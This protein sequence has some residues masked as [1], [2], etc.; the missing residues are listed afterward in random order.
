MR[1]ART[2]FSTIAGA[3][4]AI[5]VVLAVAVHL[6]EQVRGTSASSSLAAVGMT[7]REA[8]LA[9]GIGS[10][11]T[12]LERAAATES[13]RARLVVYALVPQG[14]ARAEVEVELS[15]LAESLYRDNP[16]IC[17]LAIRGYSSEGQR[18]DL[19]DNAP[20]ALVWSPDGLGWAGDGRADFDKHFKYASR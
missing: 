10:A 13:G 14:M 9:P 17:A 6:T 16:R 1:S 15:R 18:A 19:G 7:G 3:L 12:V 4:I 8:A 20:C 11:V 2:R 5:G